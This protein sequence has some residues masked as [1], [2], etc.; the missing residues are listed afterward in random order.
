MRT[1]VTILIAVAGLSAS[2]AGAS[3]LLLHFGGSSSGQDDLWKAL[4]GIAMLSGIVLSIAAGL[5]GFAL[6]IASMILRCWIRT[7]VSILLSAA[8]VTLWL[9]FLSH[10]I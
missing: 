4:L 2:V 5:S 6:A 1:L 7:V 9:Y 8:G 3:A 10:K